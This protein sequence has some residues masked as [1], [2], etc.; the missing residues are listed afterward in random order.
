MKP[1]LITLLTAGASA[2]LLPALALVL[3]FAFAALAYITRE[4][5]L[6]AEH[7]EKTRL[8]WAA[9]YREHA[10]RQHDLAGISHPCTI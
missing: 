1:L 5:R 4:R 8:L 7:W 10:R 2:A 6:N 9:N 3:A